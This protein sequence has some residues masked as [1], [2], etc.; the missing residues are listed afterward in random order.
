MARAVRRRRRGRR[1]RAPAATRSAPRPPPA[2]R[3][4]GRRPSRVAPE[5][6]ERHGARGAPRRTLS[7]TRRAA[8]STARTCASSRATS[9]RGLLAESHGF[10]VGLGDGDRDARRARAP[11][12]G[13][14]PLAGPSAPARASLARR[15]ADALRIP[16]RLRG[17]PRVRPA[18]WTP[19][20]SRRP[21]ARDAADLSIVIPAYNEEARLPASLGSIAAYLSAARVRA[22]GRGPRR[23]RRLRGPD[24]GARRGGRAPPRPSAARPPL[25]GEPRQ[26]RRRARRRLAADGA[27]VLVSDADF[28]TPIYEWE[29]LAAAGAPVAIGSRAVDE[30]L[31]K[32]Q[33]PFF[34]QAMGKLF[35]RLV[36]LVAVPGIRDTQCGFKLFSRDAA[37]ASLLAREGRPLRVRRRG[38]PPR[39]AARLS[40]SPRSRSSGST[41]RTRASRSS[42][43]RRRTGPPPDPLDDA[44][45][46]PVSRGETPTSGRGPSP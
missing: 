20:R 6:R 43:A 45:S 11:V 24:G 23:G 8:S 1:P 3:R 22:R 37:P 16:V 12:L 17:G 35:N 26:G 36:R 15:L 46:A 42:A 29:K 2:A 27:L 40:R 10:A 34:R 38:A 28:S 14:P 5:R 25:R 41:P 7:R 19:G 44:L 33:Q 18:P 9:A 21:R 4:P 30:T 31:V 13:T 32:E 39:A